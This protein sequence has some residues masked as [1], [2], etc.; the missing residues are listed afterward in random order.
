MSDIILKSINRELFEYIELDMP[1][2]ALAYGEGLCKAKLGITGDQKCYNT[3]ASCQDP[4]NYDGSETLTLSFCKNQGYIPDDRYWFPYLEKV[5]ISAASLNIGGG[6]KNKSAT[7]T[8]ASLSASFSDHPHT[9][10]IVDPY[11]SERNFDP[12]TRST[13]WAKWRARNPYYMHREVRYYSGYLNPETRQIDQDTLIKRTFFVTGFGGF[14]AGGNVTLSAKDIMTFTNNDT[15]KAPKASQ[16]KLASPLDDAQTTFTLSPSGIGDIEYPASGIVRIN[17]ESMTFTRSGDTMTVTRAAANSPAAE[18]KAGDTVQLALVITS[19]RPHEILDLLYTNYTD[20]PQHMLDKAQWAQEATDHLIR[21]YSTIITEPTGLNQLIGEMAEQM[22]FTPIWDERDA[23]LRIKAVRPSAGEPI[24]NLDDN[25]NFLEDSV[26]WNDEA[27]QLVT[28]VWIYYSQKNPNE[29]LDD[30]TNY[31]ALDVTSDVGSKSPERNNV[32]RIKEVFSRWIK[33]GGAAIDLGRKVLER[34][35]EVP[36]S[37]SFSLD[38]KDRD[39]WLGDFITAKNRHVVDLYGNPVSIPMQ[40]N[41]VQ[42]SEQGTTFTY[43]AQQYSGKTLGEDDGEGGDVGGG[44]DED[45][46]IKLVISNDYVNLN[47]REY[48]NSN[49]GEPPKSGD[50]IEFTIASG[51]KIGGCAFTDIENISE[52]AITAVGGSMTIAGL[53]AISVFQAKYYRRLYKIPPGQQEKRSFLQVKTT[54]RRISQRFKGSLDAEY[55]AYGRQADNRIVF[56]AEIDVYPVTQSLRTGDWPSGV[57]L[58]LKVSSGADI[59]GHGGASHMLYGSIQSFSVSAGT[60]AP[61][62]DLLTIGGD[63][64]DALRV[65][66]PLEIDNKGS[67]GAGGGAGENSYHGG[68]PA[69]VAGIPFGAQS[70]GQ[71]GGSGAGIPSGMQFNSGVAF[72][73][74]D[75]LVN[76]RTINVSNVTT[77]T[78]GSATIGGAGGKFSVSGYEQAQHSSYSGGSLGQNGGGSQDAKGKAGAAISEGANLI[79]W[80]NK[81]QVIGAENN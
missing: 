35:N 37:C 78:R 67:I 81:G 14:S 58:R 42:E 2:C 30:V 46:A 10:R 33:E 21:L 61:D 7:G 54:D 24:T 55:E 49:I 68:Y 77:A 36:R 11:L 63:G 57:T 9:D 62:I 13:F 52:D 15:A 47:L 28:D 22:Y 32:E 64:G 39:L 27:S 20:T 75:V 56:S 65:T 17:K 53:E 5:R 8:S 59:G 69:T 19:K 43:V 29:K 44:G 60:P 76:N 6:N 72:Q 1:K 79:T 12:Y 18:H 45:K 23:R 40:I 71:A 66:Y 38:A 25:R 4:A 70:A 41:S 73:S 16:G 74:A 48:Y 51:I 34:Y 3:R 50:I 80:I 26:S 31:S